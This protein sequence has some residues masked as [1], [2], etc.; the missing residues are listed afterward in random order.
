L[1]LELDSKSADDGDKFYCRVLA[2]SP[3]P[4]LI[5]VV[6]PLPQPPEPAMPIDPELIRVV[7]PGQ[8]ADDS[9]LE[10]MQELVKSPTE[11][12]YIGPL[13][14]NMDE[15]SLDLFSFFTY[16][17]RVGHDATRW[18][19]AQGRFGPPLR[20][21]GV[22]HPAPPLACQVSRK[23]EA[24]EVSAPFATP[25][26]DGKMM[27]PP[28]P[29]S[30]IWVLLYAQVLQVDGASW[31]NVLLLQSRASQIRDD[32]NPDLPR[33]QSA[34]EL[35]VARFSQSELDKTLTLLGLSP[36]S[37]LSVLAV[38]LLP[39]IWVTLENEA[40]RAAPLKESLG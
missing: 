10:A 30:D 2:K 18:S 6:D 25:V 16:E 12:H 22:Q 14:P 29:F 21:T 28:I 4:M 15:S 8:S 13:P 7:V 38:E 9:G 32:Q 5:S 17:L 24:I 3:D 11:V 40:P 39:E 27:R 1:W 26:L 20:V 34:L 31:R 23:P 37:G 35:A 19:T 36:N 33:P